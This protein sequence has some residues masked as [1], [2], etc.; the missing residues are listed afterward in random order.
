MQQDALP[1]T[2]GK[3]CL[4]TIGL[5]MRFPAITKLVTVIIAVVFTAAASA[6]LKIAEVFSDNMVLQRDKPVTI[7]GNSIAGTQVI[8]QFTRQ[9]NRRLQKRNFSQCLYGYHFL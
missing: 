9:Q 8:V 3:L 7:W 6:Q 1:Y 2:K 5:Y 4:Q